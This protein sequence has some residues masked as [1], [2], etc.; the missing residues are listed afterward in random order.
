MESLPTGVVDALGAEG[1]AWLVGLLRRVEELEAENQLLR[2]EN[3]ALKK[4]SG[5]DSSNSHSPPNNA[6]EQRLRAGV[7]HRQ[8][9]QGTRSTNGSVCLARLMSVFATAR[10]RG[11]DTLD[12]LTQTVYAYWRGF[13]PPA[14]LPDSG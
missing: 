1:V 12:F 13:P 6:A 2:E 10:Q 7:N 4:R 3:A 5:K 14:L 11:L 9:S 8:V